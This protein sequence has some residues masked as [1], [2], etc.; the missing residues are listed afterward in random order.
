MSWDMGK[1]GGSFMVRAV[2][3][4]KKNPIHR[5]LVGKRVPCGAASEIFFLGGH[6]YFQADFMPLIPSWGVVLKVWYLTKKIPVP[7]KTTL[8]MVSWRTKKGSERKTR[9]Q[10]VNL[11][12]SDPWTN[13][14]GHQT[15]GTKYLS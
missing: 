2:L 7:Y 4:E 8:F 6:S 10:L 13:A 12:L 5:L 1:S 11:G 9:R 14:G 3:K 15:K